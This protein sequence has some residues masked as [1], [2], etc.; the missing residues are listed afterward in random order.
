MRYKNKIKRGYSR[1]FRIICDR[2]SVRLLESKEQRYIKEVKKKKKK[3][4]EEE[5]GGGG[6]GGGAEQTR[7]VSV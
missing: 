5:E 2:S 3:E 1:S 6:G 4:E 7:V